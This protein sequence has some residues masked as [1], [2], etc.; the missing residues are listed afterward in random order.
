MHPRSLVALLLCASLLLLASAEQ[1]RPIL[2][3]TRQGGGEIGYAKVRIRRTGLTYPRL[4]RFRDARVMREVNRQIDAQ[5]RDFG[6]GR[7]GGK[8]AY[9]NVRS[10]VAYAN[11]DIFSIYA[12]AG[13]WCGGPYPTNDENISQTFDLRTGKLV[14]FE[15]LFKNY[16]ADRR[17]ILKAI[18]AKEIAELERLKASGKLKEDDCESLFTPERLE[19]S[20]FSYN[21]SSAGLQVEPSW[22][23]VIEACAD[24]V[25][26]PYSKLERFAAPD[27]LLTRMTK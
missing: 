26:V 20:S 24:V 9:Y 12:S 1:S 13:Y 7:E 25:T 14:K 15:E 19:E 6:C 16:E 5:T 21:I 8:D 27:G 23:H 10:R 3:Q 11:R 4:T 17:E 22:P 18:F 2:S